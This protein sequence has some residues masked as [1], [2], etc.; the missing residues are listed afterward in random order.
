MVGILKTIKEN[1]ELASKNNLT[2]FTFTEL[3]KDLNHDKIFLFV[4][5]YEYNMNFNQIMT[6]YDFSPEIFWSYINIFKPM[7]K[8]GDRK[9]LML[10]KSANNL[11]FTLLGN[12]VKLTEK[13]NEYL[14][15]LSQYIF[16][17]FSNGETCM[18]LSQL[19][20][21]P[22]IA[23]GYF[24]SSNDCKN[25]SSVKLNSVKEVFRYIDS[26]ESIEYK[27]KVYQKTSRLQYMMEKYYPDM[28]IQEIRS[29]RVKE[30]VQMLDGE[31]IQTHLDY[32]NKLVVDREEA[33]RERVHGTEKEKIY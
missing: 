23:N 6:L 13:E 26:I 10:K 28:S 32:I 11:Y 14:T 5:S 29:K 18:H 1:G 21:F 17:S 3:F 27:G 20:S 33:R 7:I 19:K 15:F 22:V 12:K 31:A 4:L 16:D 25:I 24:V 30:V 9:A 2:G 8:L